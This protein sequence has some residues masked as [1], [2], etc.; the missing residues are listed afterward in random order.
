MD[1][2]G[3]RDEQIL[4]NRNYFSEFFFFE[5][6]YIDHLCSY[7]L[8]KTYSENG[9]NTNIT[10]TYSTFSPMTSFVFRNLFLY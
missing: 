10:V 6:I 5:T 7:R 9:A 4:I 8:Q 3:E 1:M 2:A